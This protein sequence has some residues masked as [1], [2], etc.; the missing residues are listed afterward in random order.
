MIAPLNVSGEVGF[1]THV[2]EVN[3]QQDFTAATLYI[4]A[5]AAAAVMRY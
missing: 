4:V 1:G 3:R 5:T 2:Q